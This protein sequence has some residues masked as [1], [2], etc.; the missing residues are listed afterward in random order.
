MSHGWILDFNF[1]MYACVCD[2]GKCS[3]SFA[4]NFS[5]LLVS[6]PNT[7]NNA[8]GAFNLFFSAAAFFFVRLA[9]SQYTQ[10]LKID[11]IAA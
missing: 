11:M 10:S 7:V 9:C 4:S 5:L 8:Y 3:D 1:N 2:I 6:I